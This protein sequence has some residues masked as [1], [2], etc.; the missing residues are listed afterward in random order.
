D[1]RLADEQVERELHSVALHLREALR[2][3]P[4]EELVADTCT[5]ALHLVGEVGD[6]VSPAMSSERVTSASSRRCLNRPGLSC[7]SPRLSVTR[8]VRASVESRRSRSPPCR[9]RNRHARRSPGSRI[10]PIAGRPATREH[11]P[12]VAVDYV[13]ART[14]QS[15]GPTRS[16]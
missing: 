16:P 6:G 2:A 5:Q 9:R 4:R 7:H 12:V 10:S 8:A 14:T 11:S 13:A 3:L 1:V 15:R